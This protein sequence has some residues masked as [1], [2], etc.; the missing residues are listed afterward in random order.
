M[1]ARWLV[2]WFPIACPVEPRRPCTACRAGRVGRTSLVNDVVSGTRRGRVA[3]RA[4]HRVPGTARRHQGPGR[5]CGRDRAGSA[6][7]VQRAGPSGGDALVDSGQPFAVGRTYPGRSLVAPPGHVWRLTTTNPVPGVA[8]STS[9]GGMERAEGIPWTNRIPRAT[10]DPWTNRIPRATPVPG[11]SRVRGTNR[12]PGT[13]SSGTNQPPS[14]TRPLSSEPASRSSRAVSSKQTL[15]SYHVRRADRTSAVTGPR[16]NGAFVG[17]RRSRRSP[18]SLVGNRTPEAG[19]TRGPVGTHG[20]G[21]THRFS[22]TAGA[23]TR[24]FSAGIRWRGVP[25]AGVILRRPLHRPFGAQ[26]LGQGPGEPGRAGREPS[27]VGRSSLVRR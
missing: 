24:C 25:A 6:G 8:D 21:A 3:T 10:P 23:G 17:R 15:G 22:W 1:L 16:R 20:A 11:A 26:A 18:R 7:W 4:G 13:S 14:A 5:D 2:R 9:P 12:L 19:G 27:N